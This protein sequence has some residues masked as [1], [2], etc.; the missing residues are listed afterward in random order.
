MKRNECTEM[1]ILLSN[2]PMMKLNINVSD[3]VRLIFIDCRIDILLK[4]C[5][6]LFKWDWQLCIDPMAG[7]LHRP[8]PYHTF[9]MQ[10]SKNDK[11]QKLI[12]LSLEKLTELVSVN[13]SEYVSALK[14]YIIRD[15]ISL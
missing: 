12:K 4:K 11:H 1:I 7:Y 13:H 5:R 14:R 3:D 9:I 10:K 6:E 8:N 2:N 15:W